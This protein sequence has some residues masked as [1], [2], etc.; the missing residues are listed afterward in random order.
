MARTNIDL[1]DDLVIA[2][3]ERYHLRTKR[4]AV[5]FA[6]RRAA[7]P[8][9]GR[10]FLLALEGSGWS[11]DLSEMRSTRVDRSNTAP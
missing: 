5:N 7:G 4:E 11:G 2:V 8:A 3:M 10:D 6:L 9:L 1:D